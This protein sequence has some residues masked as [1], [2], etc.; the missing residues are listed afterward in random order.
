MQRLYISQLA[1]GNGA[2]GLVAL[3]LHS[4]KDGVCYRLGTKEVFDT[5]R[6]YLFG[7]Y[8]CA[9][10]PLLA[11]RNVEREQTKEGKKCAFH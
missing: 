6:D 5:V 1:A 4:R 3:A 9:R 7:S 10:T 8:L 11:T 2:V